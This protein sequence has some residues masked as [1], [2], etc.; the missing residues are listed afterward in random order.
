MLGGI[1]VFDP[2]NRVYWIML[3]RNDSN[4]ILIRFY[5]YDV[6]TVGMMKMVAVCSD[7]HC[8]FRVSAFTSSTTR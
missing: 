5:G 8:C 3:A 4:D 6:D 2:Q 7:S 1:S